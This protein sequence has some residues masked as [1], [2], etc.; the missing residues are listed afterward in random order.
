[1]NLYFNAVV[2]LVATI[3]AFLVLAKALAALRAGRLS[4]PWGGKGLSLSLYG[5]SRLAIEQ[6][7]VVDGKRRL[8]L[9]R[10]DRQHF[11]LMTGGP[12]DL[13]VPVSA[14]VHPEGLLP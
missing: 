8:L 1:M 3:A 4:L 14:A 6:A 5:S 10:A 11:L 2:M 12:A 9:V 7:C 13:I